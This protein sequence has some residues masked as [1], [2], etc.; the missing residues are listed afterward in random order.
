MACKLDTIKSNNINQVVSTFIG[1]GKHFKEISEGV[2]VGT[3]STK[4][5][6][7]KLKEITESN[8]KRSQE[9][10]NNKFNNN[11][12]FVNNWYD[13]IY[14]DTD[15]Q[16]N[17]K[18]PK[19][20]E[21]AWE[22]KINNLDIIEANKILQEYYDELNKKDA[23][24]LVN[25]EKE[26]LGLLEED[27]LFETKKDFNNLVDKN[28]KEVFGVSKDLEFNEDEDVEVKKDLTNEIE[29]VLFKGNT[30][31]LD[32]K[33]VLTNILNSE[34]LNNNEELFN[35]ANALLLSTKANVKIVKDTEL[36]QP[37]TYMQFNTSTNT[38][39]LSLDNLSSVNSVEQAVRNFLHEIFHERSLRIIRQPKNTSEQKLV[40]DLKAFYEKAKG[41]II[42]NDFIHEMSSF[43]EFTA[44]MFSN[45]AFKDEVKKMLT[46]KES[47]WQKLINYFKE[48]L[49]LKDQKYNKLM[50]DILQLIDTSDEIFNSNEVL[51]S[52]YNIGL[53]RKNTKKLEELDDKINN[54][55]EVLEIQSSRLEN[56]AKFKVR[57]KDVI[58][59][60]KK[61]AEMLDK[62][63]DEYKF[64]SIE[65]FTEFM[66]GQLYSVDKRLEDPKKFDSKIFNSSKAYIDSFI[67]IQ[68]SIKKSLDEL[69]DN[70]SINK[71]EY[72]NTLSKIRTLSGVALKAK[73][74][75]ID[76]AK[77]HIEKNNSKFLK[78]F[79]ETQLRFKQ[80]FRNE[81]KS[82][83][84]PNNQIENYVN[85]K[86]AEN[87]ELIN[88][89][90]SEEFNEMINNPIV[91]ISQISSLMNSEKDFLHPIIQIF[92]SILDKI[93][94]TYQDI[95]QPRLLDLQTDTN[96]FLKNKRTKSSDENYKN[97]VEWSEDGTAFLKGEYKI[98]FYNKATTL[99]NARDKAE[100]EHGVNSK[101]YKEA[102][103]NYNK[104]R[105]ENTRLLTEEGDSRPIRIP[106]D[107][108]KNNLND[109]TSEEKEFL[110]KIRTLAEDSNKQYQIKTKSLKK[111][112]MSAEFYQLP[113]IRKDTLS[114]LKSGNLVET[115]KEFYKENFKQQSD[116]TDVGQIIDSE[117]IYKIYTDLSGK[118]VKYIPIHFRSKIEKKY[119][120]IDLPTLYALEFQNAVKFKVK[121]NVSADLIMFKEV[122]QE[123][124]FI[125]VKGVGNRL[126]TNVF[127][128]DNN[129]VEYSKEDAYLI[130]MLD[131]MLNNRLY[132]KTSEYAGKI[133]GQDVNKVESFMRSIVSQASMALNTIGAPANL[134]TAKSQ[135]FLEVLRDPNL[136]RNNVLKAEKFFGQN[137]GGF[138]DDMGRNVYKSLGNQLL[139]SYGGLISYHMLQ[140]N[141]EKNKTLAFAGT[142]PLFFFQES[143]EHYNQAVH[144]MTIL[145]AAK[146]LNEKGEYLDKTGKVVETKEQAASLLDIATLEDGKL[147][148]TIKKPFYTTLDTI[149]EYSKGGK[150][151]VRSYINSSLVK[152]QGNYN[153]DYQAELQRHFYGKALFHFKKHIISPSLSR[154]RG[155]STNLG[156]DED[157]NLKWN[158]D[159]QRPDE[160]NYVT[161]IRWMKNHVLPNIKKLQFQLLTKEWS[162]MDDWEKGN[163]KK[164]M[165]ELAIIMTMATLASLFAAAAGD[166]DDALWYAAAIFRRTQSEAAQYYD[167]NEAWRV[168]K[169]PIST[170]NFLEESSDIVAATINLIDPLEE[171]RLERMKKETV[172][173]V[174]FIPGNK[175]FKDAKQGYNY[176]NKN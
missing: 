76:A 112:I 8:I 173:M 111:T 67:S 45:K 48:L 114:T 69:L 147:G 121:N 156:K 62:T 18:I 144:S 97:L 71:E 118:E 82:L 9:W 24:A 81:A 17:F 42:S 110:L 100:A 25:E 41:F 152:A 58:F 54:V 174:K 172:D 101:E 117:N 126:I 122:I 4:F 123:N 102:I 74:E 22:S 139:L 14:N 128:K 88:K 43:E 146:I 75:L 72:D 86:M 136:S 98:E 162:E 79:K 36:K 115:A 104:F 167:I 105:N 132:D 95:I 130:K 154:W 171:E 109:L 70:N 143:G 138:M 161:T 53:K 21:I 31:N 151:S 50:S 153:S 135:S 1:N 158:Y 170:L 32:G 87:R 169:N 84:L 37:D 107:K 7:Y 163:I 2:L 148:V 145:D 56:D 61:A 10:I 34:I 3:P 89:E 77:K 140:N 116:Q 141:F 175:I 78:G 20:L 92:S 55:L 160:G 65:I 137:I 29:T 134:I 85:K 16:I 59:E 142:K 26:R 64:K 159:L 60:I 96:K 63:S 91:D 127:S 157:I 51:E 35:L 168:L 5:D 119:Q 12:K 40:A 23:Q 80:Q 155:L 46:P 149:N 125:K 6:M 113:S 68:D 38:V 47:F 94:D 73:S 66:S 103:T 176:L 166:D 52:K 39:E 129:P 90:A 30:S 13:I 164:T 49:N 108:W 150:A 11:P 19:S 99:K 131:T 15:I 133:F 27:V 124:K 33:I 93:K 165:S 57:I 106:L 28:A 120:S 44:A 83:N